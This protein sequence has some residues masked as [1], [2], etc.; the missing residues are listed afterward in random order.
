MFLPGKSHRQRGLAGYSPW[1]HKESD[2]TEQL[3][4]HT[5]TDGITCEPYQTSKEELVLLQVVWEKDKEEKLP[6]SF[7]EASIFMIPKPNVEKKGKLK[8]HFSYKYKNSER[9]IS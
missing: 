9:N 1:G 7:Y 6:R 3:S 8:H 2:R 4:T 5:Y